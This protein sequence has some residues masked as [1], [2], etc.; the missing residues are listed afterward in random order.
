[1]I[2]RITSYPNMEQRNKEIFEG[3]D[4]TGPMAAFLGSSHTPGDL[5]CYSAS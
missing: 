5:A 3:A 2:S 4:L 1:M